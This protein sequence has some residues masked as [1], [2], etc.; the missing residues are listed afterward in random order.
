MPVVA[1]I[2]RTTPLR[3]IVTVD[4]GSAHS[5]ARL[6][7]GQVRCW[8]RNLLGQLG[9]GIDLGMAL[10][11]PSAVRN[12]Q[13]TENLG[14]VTQLS[15]H[16]NHTCV[17]LT[18]GQARCWGYGE[19]NALGDGGTTNQPLPRVVIRELEACRSGAA[20]DLEPEGEA[21]GVLVLLGDVGD[22]AGRAADEDEAPDDVGGQAEVGEG[23]SGRAGAVDRQVLAGL[24]LVGARPPR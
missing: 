23:G 5:C 17:R 4:A 10:S 2:T 22:E 6:T 18:N 7:N 9:T 15:T 21:D 8:G 3:G 14:A 11:I 12:R 16:T 1:D 13:N 24:A 19:T 20:L